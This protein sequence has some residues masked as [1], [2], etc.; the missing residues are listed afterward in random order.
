MDNGDLGRVLEMF[1]EFLEGLP[2]E[3]DR[4]LQVLLSN[5]KTRKITSMILFRDKQLGAEDGAR[6]PRRDSLPLRCQACR[7]RG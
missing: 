5:S 6:A 2:K 1:L 7:V 3:D 4:V